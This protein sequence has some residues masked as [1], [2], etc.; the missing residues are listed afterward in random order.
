MQWTKAQA[1]AI[2]HEAPSALLISAAAGSG[3]TAVLSQRIVSRCLAEKLAPEAVAVMTFT[4]KAAQNMRQRI[5]RQLRESKEGPLRDRL[6]HQLPSMQISTIHSFCL[7]VVR[8]YRQELLDEAGRPLL[9]ADFGILDPAAGELLLD[10]VVADVLQEHYEALDAGQAPEGLAEMLWAM[11]QGKTDEQLR[12]A[13]IDALRFLRSLPDGK[14]FVDASLAAMDQ[15]ALA[16]AE[17]PSGQE[18]LRSLREALDLA[19]DAIR[20]LQGLPGAAAMEDPGRKTAEAIAY[21]ASMPGYLAVLQELHEALPS[22]GAAEA[23]DLA[24]AAGKRL[25]APPRF[26]RAKAPKTDAQ[27]EK[28]ALIDCIEQ[29]MGP[30]LQQLA[31]LWKEGSASYERAGLDKALPVFLRSSK[32]WAQSLAQD[33]QI[34]AQFFQLVAAVAQ[35]FQEAKWTMG[36]I[37]YGDFEH[38]ALK[39]LQDPVCAEAIR[40]RIKEVYVD[41]YQDTNNLQEAILQA[42]APQQL[43]MV[44]DMKQSIYR[45]RHANPL[46][47]AQKLKDFRLLSLHEPSPPDPVGEAILLNRNFRS[48]PALIAQING[49]FSFLMREETAEI[50]YDEQQAMEAGRS[51]ERFPARR[52]PLVPFNFRYVDLMAVDE[53]VQRAYPGASTAALEA[54]DLVLAVLEWKEKGYAYGEMAVLARSNAQCA[55]VHAALQAAGLPVTGGKSQ[56]LFASPELRLFTALVQV[57][58]NAQQDLPLAALLRS[59]LHGRPFQEEA[60]WQIANAAEV[61][62]HLEPHPPFHERL[63]SYAEHGEDLALRKRVQAF[64]ARLQGWRDLAKEARVPRVL[65]RIMDTSGWRERVARLPHGAERLQDWEDFRRWAERLAQRGIGSLPGFAKH[66]RRLMEQVLQLQDFSQPPEAKD[67]V[68]VMT[69]HGSKGLEFPLVF[70]HASSSPRSSHSAP[71]HYDAKLGLV[72]QSFDLESGGRFDNPRQRRLQGL[73]EKQEAAERYRLLYVAMTRAEEA[74]VFLGSSRGLS[75][76]SLAERL[77]FVQARQKKGPIRLEVLELCTDDFSLALAYQQLEKPGL[78]EEGSAAGFS[79]QGLDEVH[80]KLSLAFAAKQAAAPGEE[81]PSGPRLQLPGREAREAIARIKGLFYDPLPQAHLQEVPSKVTVTSLEKL[82][83]QSDWSD[84]EASE[85]RASLG[86]LPDLHAGMEMGLRLR[87]PRSAE[88]PGGKEAGT[89]LH[90]IFQWLPVRD[91]LLPTLD[92]K[93]AKERYQELLQA[94]IEQ[95]AFPKEEGQRAIDDWPLVQAFLAHPLALRLA[96]VEAAGGL[97]RRELPFTLAV[98][99]LGLQAPGKELSLVQGMIDLFFVE[100]GKAIL[101]DYKSDQLRGRPEQVDAIMRKRYQEQMAAYAE[102]IRRILKMELGGS[103]LYLIRQARLIE[104]PIKQGFDRDFPNG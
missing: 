71:L 67:A 66:L 34:L 84:P 100:D 48:H 73:L 53:A 11:D 2:A 1:K 40:G 72:A 26:A 14:A 87:D 56:A 42:L 86:Q 15:E 19:Q 43:F 30:A 7:Q 83:F 29:G 5:E 96:D 93:A 32:E 58:D 52:G 23:F 70:Y 90:R 24:H 91:F 102:A 78:W 88:V 75:K 6:L 20:E 39:I 49:F 28:N 92:E 79:F 12:K 74:F 59:D 94:W 69:L 9:D 89:R 101:V 45:F 77:D 50:D 3:K 104:M 27:H 81:S 57:L 10:Q 76:K 16:F 64:L 95:L 31:G 37:D 36:Q 82:G 98:P 103:Y 85:E 62:E 38:L 65:Q 4:D 44:G 46:L 17:G 55:A 18:A 99:A 54:L 61:L 60:L 47:F 80:E 51:A 63:R 22:L 33:R 25:A 68:A 21:R 8:A 41:E 13:L 97:V 35:R